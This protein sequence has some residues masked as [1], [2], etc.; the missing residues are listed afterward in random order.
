MMLNRSPS[1]RWRRQRR[2]A[3]RAWTMEAP[4]IEPETSIKKTTV[5][6]PGPVEGPVDSRI[7]GAVDSPTAIDDPV[8]ALDLPIRGADS[9]ALTAV[10]SPIRS[11]GDSLVRA[12]D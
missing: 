1:R 4:F 5:C 11:A 6:R 3:A 12:V 2:R 7:A 9:V 10:D 8:R